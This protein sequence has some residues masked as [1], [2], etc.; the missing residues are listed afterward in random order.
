MLRKRN[1]SWK[2]REFIGNKVYETVMH[3]LSEK[4]A[5]WCR[6]PDSDRF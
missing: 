5:Q 6:E 2:S 3:V 1:P 4:R